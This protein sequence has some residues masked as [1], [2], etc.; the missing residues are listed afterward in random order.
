[1]QSVQ[2]AK[3]VSNYRPLAIGTP[4][5]SV[6]DPNVGCVLVVRFCLKVV[7]E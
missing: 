2:V 7:L 6:L 3:L 1:M 5:S 4:V